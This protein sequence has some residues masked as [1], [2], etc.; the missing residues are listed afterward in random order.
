ME[1]VD[2][3]KTESEPLL[4]RAE[5]AAHLLCVG[6]STI[7]AMLADGTLPA[8]RFGRATRIRRSDIDALIERRIN[9]VT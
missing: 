4:L 5:Q 9:G 3:P 1:I 8:V 7:Y 2:R 6:R